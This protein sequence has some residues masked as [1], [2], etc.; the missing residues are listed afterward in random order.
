[1]APYI[2]QRDWLATQAM[3]SLI[4]AH[5]HN[6][7]PELLAA[8][9]YEIADRMLVAAGAVEVAGGYEPVEQWRYQDCLA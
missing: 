2:C 8:T 7:D 9:S 5:P 6:G 4:I 1:M 3:K